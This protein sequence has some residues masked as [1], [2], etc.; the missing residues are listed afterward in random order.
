[1]SEPIKIVYYPAP[2]KAY[3]KEELREIF[4]KFHVND[5]IIAA[6]KQ[7]FQVR[8]ANASLDAAQLRLTEREAGH[9]GGRIHEITDFREE[10]LSYLRTR[11]PDAAGNTPATQRKR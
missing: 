10:L 2:P 7:I 11:E 1:M 5:P 8:F 4:C 6:I 9:A 3:S